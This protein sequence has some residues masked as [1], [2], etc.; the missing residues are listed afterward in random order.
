MKWIA[1]LLVLLYM[2]MLLPSNQLKDT[3]RPLPSFLQPESKKI[4][5][6][7]FDEAV[8]PG[9]LK[10][11]CAERYAFDTL[12]FRQHKMVLFT[13]LNDTTV[14]KINGQTLFFHKMQTE[15]K[16][17]QTTMLFAGH[18]YTIRFQSTEVRKI[19]LEYFIKTATLEIRRGKEKKTY[20]L[21]GYYS[22]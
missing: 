17:K 2:G 5:L 16:G 3:T 4:V 13:N 7:Y 20:Q 14:L 15:T 6:G 19:D 22:C 9:Q 1:T 12:A 11:D 18:G 21:L 8:I 10:Y